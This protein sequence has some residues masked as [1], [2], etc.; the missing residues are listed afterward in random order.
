VDG[1]TACPQDEGAA[2]LPAAQGQDFDA[3]RH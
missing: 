1:R 3:R 2:D